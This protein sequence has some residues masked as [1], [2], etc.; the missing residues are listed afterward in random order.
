MQQPQHNSRQN[1][2]SRQI[3]AGVTFLICCLLVIWLLVAKL[4]LTQAQQL[5]A[6]ERP[7]VSMVTDEEEFLD[8][9]LL[10][11]TTTGEDYAPAQTPEDLDNEAQAGPQTGADLTSQ[12]EQGDPVQTVTQQKP[13]P[14][15]EQPKPT[16][17]KPAT[18]VDNKAEQE[19]ALA[20]QTKNNLAN[21][22]ANAQN[23]NNAQN[24]T[25]DEANAGRTS[26]NPASSA[27][28]NATGKRPG[29]DGTVG[30][31]WKMPVYSRNIPSNEVGKVVFEVI[32][33]RDGS[34][35]KIT[36]IDANGLTSATIAKCRAEINS[37]RFTHPNPDTAEPTTAR[38]IFTF[39]D[40]K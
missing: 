38:V 36:Q 16:T 29:I 33:N 10:K 1:T 18:P 26:G 15:K 22:F 11:P 19:K 40:P 9:E 35:G 13:S 31:G 12:G 37:K 6:E 27:G 25:K 24:G 34:V 23:K 17:A 4:G 3:A 32:V 2:D 28:A 8:V 39:V 20:A 14:I 7:F 5:V 30:G 21:A